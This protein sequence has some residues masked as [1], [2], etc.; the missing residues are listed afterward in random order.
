[1]KIGRHR[2][3]FPPLFT[4][5]MISVYSGEERDCGPSSGNR[6]TQL[7]GMCLLAMSRKKQ[8]HNFGAIPS[9]IK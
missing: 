8:T 1:M 2:Y 7:K 4:D 5:L 6:L 3:S 9:C